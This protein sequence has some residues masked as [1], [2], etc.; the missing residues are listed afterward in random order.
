MFQTIAIYDRI[1]TNSEKLLGRKFN[2]K[3]SLTL[4]KYLAVLYFITTFAYADTDLTISFIA[5]EIDKICS[6]KFNGYKIINISKPINGLTI[7]S[8]NPPYREFPNQIIFK[9]D[10][11]E[12][13]WVRVYEALCIGIEDKVSEVLDLHTT[14]DVVDVIFGKNI[15]FGEKFKKINQIANDKNMILIPYTHFQHM[16]GFADVKSYYTIDKT[17]FLEMAVILKGDK[18]TERY[19]IDTCMMYDM[20]TIKNTQFIYQDNTYKIVSETDNRQRWMILFKG[21]D[22][23]FE[24]IVDKKIKVEKF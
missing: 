22:D 18:Y 16:H 1:I 7:V 9:F 21:I 14:D 8:I 6:Q 12:K 2:M 24:Y 3:R 13:K 5:S 19:P 23:K 10:S 4:I 15:L 17:K 11:K 20:P